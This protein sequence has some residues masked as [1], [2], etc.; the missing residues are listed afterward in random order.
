MRQTQA[1]VDPMRSFFQAKPHHVNYLVNWARGSKVIY[2]ETPKVG[3]TTIKQ[4]LQYSELGYDSSRLPVD[5]HNRKLSPLDS[6]KNKEHEFISCLTSEEYFTFAF[7]RNPLTRTLSAY[8]D[9]ITGRPGVTTPIQKE[10]GI[11][12]V[13]HIP[14]FAE[15][16]DVIYKTEPLDMNPHWAPQTFL[17]GYANI[18]Y[19]YLGRFEFFNTSIDQLVART[20]LKVSP[21]AISQGQKHA[22]SASDEIGKYYTPTLLKRV[23]EIFHDDFRYFGYGWTL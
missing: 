14:S 2:V 5:I 18:R 4:I 19:D 9:K 7:V 15:F 17:L 16:I 22:T 3:C 20:A 6:P 1:D 8:L 23:Q 11:D 12:P 13:K 21:G 10:M